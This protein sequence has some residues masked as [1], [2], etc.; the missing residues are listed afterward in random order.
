MIDGHLRIEEALKARE[1]TVPVT[2]V[3]LSKEE[4][5]EILLT[6][7]P[8]AAMAEENAE[9]LQELT[10]L[11]KDRLAEVEEE[12]E[13]A[14]AGAAKLI[15][16][17]S[18]T[19][20]AAGGGNPNYHSAFDDMATEEDDADG[21]GNGDS[22]LIDNTEVQRQVDNAMPRCPFCDQILRNEAARK[23]IDNLANQVE[24]E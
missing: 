16:D 9:T 15:D 6:L 21:M 2:Y 5:E 14:L 24:E 23:R 8:I 11:V 13:E 3:Q 12:T 1:S 17:L 18:T 19:A 10:A 20:M 7:D 22:N 4:E